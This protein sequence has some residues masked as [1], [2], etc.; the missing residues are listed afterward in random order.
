[1]SLDSYVDRFVKAKHPFILPNSPL[2]K[3]KTFLFK[4]YFK[5][6]LLKQNYIVSRHRNVGQ[7]VSE[8]NMY[9]HAMR[10][11]QALD[12]EI[13]MQFSRHGN[14]YVS[15][16]N[17]KNT[18]DIATTDT[19]PAM[20]TSETD[21]L[22]NPELSNGMFFSVVDANSIQR[23]NWIPVKIDGAPMELFVRV[24]ATYLVTNP[25]FKTIEF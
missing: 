24:H 8:Y 22:E 21:T 10:Q 5:F 19:T 15:I 6:I 13:V 20:F 11:P 14:T 25:E 7:I 4:E 1:M 9:A 23:L 3:E 2:A 18:D 17:V 16:V 12:N